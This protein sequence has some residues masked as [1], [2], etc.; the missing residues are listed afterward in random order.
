MR[1][2]P[3]TGIQDRRSSNAQLCLHELLQV[4]KTA[5]GSSVKIINADTNTALCSCGMGETVRDTVLDDNSP[6]ARWQLAPCDGNWFAC[7]PASDNT[8]VSSFN[9]MP[10]CMCNVGLRLLR[11]SHHT[12]NGVESHMLFWRCHAAGPVLAS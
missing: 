3:S 11:S 5:F 8:E 2:L 10:V 1:I 12:R 6:A 9:S 7:R 4:D